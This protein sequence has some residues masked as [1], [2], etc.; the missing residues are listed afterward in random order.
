MTKD[1]VHSQH[2]CSV[3]GDGGYKALL[4]LVVD[5]RFICT[6]C[7]RVARK[8]KHLCSPRRLKDA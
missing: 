7:G 5:A 6:R 4:E 2:L 1:R 3:F 8:K